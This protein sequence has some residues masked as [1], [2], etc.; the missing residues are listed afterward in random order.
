MK[1]LFQRYNVKPFRAFLAPAVQLPLFLGMF[2]GLKKMPHIYHDEFATGGMFWFTDLTV[3]DPYY[4]LPVTSTL[5]FLALIELGKD[6]M[7]AQQ[8]PMQGQLMVNIFRGMSLFMLPV[9]LGFET[10]MLC[11]W[12]T[13]NIL[14]MGQ[15]SLLK[16]PAARKY[17]DIWDPPKPVPGTA[18]AKPESLQETMQKLALRLQ[19]KPVSSKEQMEKHNQD[20]EAQRQAVRMVRA[21]R[22]ARNQRADKAATK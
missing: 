2:F 19:G 22:A 11:Y 14:T 15:T 9:C 17:F 8:G 5:T 20:I 1:A 4:I 10:S 21:S 13:N 18:T 16:L 7:V 3:T 6:Q 12:T